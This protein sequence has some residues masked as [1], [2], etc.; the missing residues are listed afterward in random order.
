MKKLLFS[1]AVVVAAVFI[2]SCS[3][4]SSKGSPNRYDQKFCEQ[5]QKKFDSMDADKAISESDC[6]SAIQQ[7]SFILDD[8]EKAGD[9]EKFMRKNKKEAEMLEYLYI[10][11]LGE[12]FNDSF[13]NDL[14]SKMDT[15][16]YRFGKLTEKLNPLNSN[17]SYNDYDWD[18]SD[19]SFDESEWDTP[20]FSYD[21]EDVTMPD[22]GEIELDDLFSDEY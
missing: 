22:F 6:R 17:H 16:R 10:V 12:E 9:P 7:I 20:D 18:D 5:L 3:S 8:F 1:L 21:E 13:P 19:Y 15:I 4:D 14:K 11:M 2:S